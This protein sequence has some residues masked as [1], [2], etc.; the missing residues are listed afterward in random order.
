MVTSKY[1]LDFMPLARD[2]LSN[3][4][5]Y[6]LHN[7]SSPTA[8]HRLMSRIEKATNNLREMPFSAPMCM[9]DTLCEK[10]YRKLIIDHYILFFIVDKKKQEVIVM[11]VLYERRNY[12][13]L[14]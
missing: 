8:A 12:I 6:I 5:E 9:D 1:K 7:L 14:F 11:R 2:D 3:I 13:P 10:G 4:F